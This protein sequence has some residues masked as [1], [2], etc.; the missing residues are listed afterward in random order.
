ML[1]LIR[2][3]SIKRAARSFP[4]LSILCIA[5]IPKQ[6]SALLFWPTCHE[7]LPPETTGRF[8]KI[9]GRSPG[10]GHCRNSW[11]QLAWLS[12]IARG[13]TLGPRD[14]SSSNLVRPQSSMHSTYVIPRPEQVSLLGC[15]GRQT[16]AP[17]DRKTSHTVSWAFLGSSYLYST[18]KGQDHSEDYRKSLFDRRTMNLF[19]PGPAK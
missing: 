16:G 9:A 15:P 12:S 14:L 13:S 7:G 10:A 8:S 3:V 6:N 1:G 11:L 17:L 4:R 19:L 2:D 5:I 18:A